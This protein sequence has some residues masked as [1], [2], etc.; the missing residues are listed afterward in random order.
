MDRLFTGR[1]VRIQCRNF[2]GA[3]YWA[4]SYFWFG[5]GCG[6]AVVGLLFVLGPMPL[7]LLYLG[8]GCSIGSFLSSG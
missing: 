8:I 7:A 1:S 3:G 5:L 2:S 6:L 4:Q